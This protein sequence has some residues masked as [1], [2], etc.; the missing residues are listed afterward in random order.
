VTLDSLVPRLR[1]PA[2]GAPLALDRVP[3]P[4]PE[5]GDCGV[6]RC[7]CAADYPVLDGVPVLRT[8]A[9]DRRSIADDRALA[10]G[11][12]VA[13]VVSAV[14]D[15][16]ALDAL[17]D[18]L[19]APLCPWPLHKIGALRRL[20]LREPLRSAGL[21]LR[22]RRVRAMLRQRDRLTAEDWLATFYWH[23]PEVYDP[24]NYFFFRFGTPRHL[25]TLGLASVLP[26]SVSPVLDLACGYGHLAHALTAEG[27]AVAGLDQNLHQAWLARH[28]VAPAAAF[29]CADASRPLPFADGAFAS[30]VC[31]DAFHYVRDKGG[32]VAELDRVSD[33]G[34]LLFPT[35]GNALVSEPDGHEL[36]P[37][38]YETLFDGWHV[39][40][41]SDDTLFE[42]YRDGLGPDLSDSAAEAGPSKWLSIAATRGDPEALLRDHGPLDGWPHAA[43]R[44]ALNPLYEPDGDRHVLQLPSPWYEAEHGRLCDYMPPVVGDGEEPTPGLVA[45][46]VFVGLPERYARPRRPRIVAANRTLGALLRRLRGAG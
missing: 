20:S 2:C 19:A 22:R 23:A 3:Q 46:A 17:V 35:V 6:L 36:A 29:V 18:L 15:G 14:V 39:R 21:A 10:P 12:D 13:D 16:R 45:Q 33:G 32:A 44:L 28:Y 4:D 9:L 11:P 7:P 30:A 41:T 25:A 26:D 5:A 37:D 1:C 8:G 43:G 31:S 40:I 24:F 38:A 42:R 34:P 27:R